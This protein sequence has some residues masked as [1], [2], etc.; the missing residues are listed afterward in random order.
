MKIYWL[1]LALIIIS[2]GKKQDNFKIGDDVVIGDNSQISIQVKYNADEFFIDVG[3][4]FEYTPDLITRGI[5]DSGFEYSIFPPLPSSITFDIESGKLSGKVNDISTGNMYFVEA[6]KGAYIGSTSII[7]NFVPP[8]IDPS[9]SNPEL[10]FTVNQVTSYSPLS[11]P[12][13]VSYRVSPNL[14]EGLKIDERTGAISGTPTTV[15]SVT[16]NTNYTIYA[17]NNNGFEK[18]SP[19]IIKRVP[20]LESS[21]TMGSSLGVSGGGEIDLSSYFI[22]GRGNLTYAII[23]GFGSLN[24]SFITPADRDGDVTV[25]ATDL[26][27]SGSSADILF[28]IDKVTAACEQTIVAAGDIAR[29]RVSINGSYYTTIPMD[30]LT[31]DG[32][33]TLGAVSN[34]NYYSSSGTAYIIPGARYIEIEVQTMKVATEVNDKNLFLNISNI[35]GATNTSLLCEILIKP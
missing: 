30:Y 31:S 10:R 3:S 9:F 29:V 2:C 11:N 16:S 20:V 33:G 28:H 32:P 19:L 35:T 8:I 5:Y 7:L 1:A 24:G 12:G 14:P 22:G 34:V 15:D 25:R 6:K 17:K 23:S 18:S 21:I 13:A 4:D 26:G 27:G